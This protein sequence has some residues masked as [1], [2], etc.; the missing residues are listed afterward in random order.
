MKRHEQKRLPAPTQVRQSGLLAGVI[1]WHTAQAWCRPL[2]NL[3]SDSLM[4]FFEWLFLEVFPQE[5]L[6]L[7]MDNASAHHAASMQAFL[8]LFE[9]RIRVLWLPTYSP[10][11]NLIERFWKHLKLR[12]TANRLFA[13]LEDMFSALQAELCRQNCPDYPFRF[14]F[15]KI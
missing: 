7:V 11:L 13:S 15:S 8:S 5:K 12:I 14:S 3:S 10:D 4:Q 9:H 1:D 2:V 6:V